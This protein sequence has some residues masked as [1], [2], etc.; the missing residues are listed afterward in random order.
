MIMAIPNRPRSTRLRTAGALAIAA[1][2]IWALP[3]HAVS[4]GNVILDTFQLDD[5]NVYA[6]APGDLLQA[7][8]QFGS[9]IASIGDF[10][11][12]GVSD[13]AVGARLDDDGGADKGAVYILLL[14][15][16]GSV[17]SPSPFK[18][19]DDLAGD[20]NDAF[21]LSAGG[22]FGNAIAWLG[23][24]DSDGNQEIAVGEALADSPTNAGAVWI[25]DL[26]ASA[27][28]QSG[29]AIRSG[30]SNFLALGAEDR[31]GYSLA[32]AGDWN[33]D[34]APELA[35]GVLQDDDGAA[36]N[37][38]LYILYLDP[39]SAATAIKSYAKISDTEGGFT[40]T[41]TNG[42]S[43]ASP[44]PPSTT[45]TATPRRTSP[46][47]PTCRRPTARSGSCSWTPRARR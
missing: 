33:G 10:D 17:K 6:S 23:D 11:G 40:G 4:V 1:A 9:T 19:A 43:S 29:F 5:T 36:N 31:F 30:S 46:S 8:D 28:P 38:A 39:S 25:I 26:D 45:S 18:I 20:P 37:G 24:Y 22:L 2:L 12:D 47:A 3:A 7:G 42:A 44:S 13:I 41:L 16:D 35:V 34:G 32:N 15:P 21:Q 14:N 27:V